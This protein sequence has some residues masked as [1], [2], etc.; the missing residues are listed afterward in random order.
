M[1]SADAARDYLLRH[2]RDRPFTVSVGPA[3]S[4]GRLFYDDAMAMNFR[5]FDAKLPEVFA[6]MAAFAGHPDAPTVY[7]ASIDV[8]QYFDG[9]ARRQPYRPRRARTAG[10]HLDGQPHPDR[11]A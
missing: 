9:P 2:H 1:R 8:H 7:L 5:T 3:G 6:R 10:Q 11:R 4:G